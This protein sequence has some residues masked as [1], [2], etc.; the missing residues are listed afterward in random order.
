MEIHAVR[1]LLFHIKGAEKMSGML[2]PLPALRDAKGSYTFALFHL[3][4]LRGW[5]S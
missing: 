4:L 1:L 3:R 2:H 5:T